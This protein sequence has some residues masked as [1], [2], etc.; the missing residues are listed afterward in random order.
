MLKRS[1]IYLLLITLF[2]IPLDVFAQSDIYARDL[3][4]VRKIDGKWAA[5]LYW[6]GLVDVRYDGDV[7]DAFK[8]D[9]RGSGNLVFNFLEDGNSIFTL[10][11][12]GRAII[13]GHFRLRG[14]NRYVNFGANY[15]T[16]GYGIRDNA[17]ILQFKNSGGAWAA[18]GASV[19]CSLPDLDASND[20]DFIWNENDTSDRI[21][22]FLV[23]SGNRTIDLSGNLTVN[24]DAN[25]N[26][27][28]PATTLTVEANSLVNQDLTSDAG[29]TFAGTTLSGL[30]ASRL[31][32]SNG[33]K[34]LTSSDLYGWVTQTANQVLVADDGDGTITFST[35]QDIASTSSPTFANITVPGTT[36]LNT[37]AYTWP[38]SD[39]SSGNS[40]TTNGAGTF[41]WTATGDLK[42]DGTVPLSAN[43]DSGLYEI[44]A[45]QFDAEGS[46]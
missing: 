39:G 20:L 40:L 37:I 31:L 35:P 36:T 45:G 8:V 17:G 11:K 44:E 25:F 12:A 1:F 14:S 26:F 15:G 2:L 43:W 38:A 3:F 29:P 33:S 23:N 42:A 22:N 27:P 7:A 28:N 32:S 13:N 4:V 41:I 21:L 30:T 19:G 18:M 46:D 9:Y 5:P 16:G 24:S 10:S 34:A 6:T